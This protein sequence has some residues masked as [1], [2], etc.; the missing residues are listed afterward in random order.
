MRAARLRNRDEVVSECAEHG[1]LAFSVRDVRRGAA[2]A[3]SRRR[4]TKIFG[5]PRP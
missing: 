2:E 3:R 4:P 5:E 1:P